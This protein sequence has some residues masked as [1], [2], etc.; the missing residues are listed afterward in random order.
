[1]NKA[2]FLA[3]LQSSRDRWEAQLARVDPARMTEPG[4]SGAWSVKDIIAHIAWHEL[5][6]VGVLR[7]RIFSGSDWWTL[8]T[9]ERNARIYAASQDR[10]LPE[11]LAEARQAYAQMSELAQ[12]LTDEDLNSAARFKDMPPDW[13]PWQVLAGNTFEHYDDH[14]ADIRAWLEKRAE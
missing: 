11:V 3:T 9:D 10:P 12:G 5:Q 2:E 4:A 1:M 7:S 8:P 13:L 14:A 6:M